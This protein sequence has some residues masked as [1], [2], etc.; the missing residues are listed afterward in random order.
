VKDLLAKTYSE[1]TSLGTCY[2]PLPL[3]YALIAVNPTASSLG[4]PLIDTMPPLT[5]IPLHYAAALETALNMSGG[6]SFSDVI[7]SVKYNEESLCKF[8]PASRL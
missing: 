3:L 5:D 2:L 6:E 4:V 8:L 1:A 7:A